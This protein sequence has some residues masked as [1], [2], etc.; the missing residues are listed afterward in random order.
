MEENLNGKAQICQ[1][2]KFGTFRICAKSFFKRVCKAIQWARRLIIILSF[3]LLSYLATANSEGSGETAW[4]RRLAGT[5]AAHQGEQYHYT[6]DRD[7]GK[8]QMMFYCTN[9]QTYI[10]SFLTYQCRV[11]NI[12]T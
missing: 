7:H 4:L 12:S 9:G 11:I 10:I 8:T 1:Y 3:H 5:L 2:M 6:M